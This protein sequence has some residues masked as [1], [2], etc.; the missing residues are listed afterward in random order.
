M[1]ELRDK[2]AAVLEVATGG[3]LINPDLSIQEMLTEI[4]DYLAW[5]YLEGCEVGRQWAR[6]QS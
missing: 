2:L 6:S 3:A 1:D 5:T 4:E